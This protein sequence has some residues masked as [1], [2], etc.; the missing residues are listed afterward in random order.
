MKKDSQNFS[1]C[2]QIFG[3]GSQVFAQNST[4]INSKFFTTELSFLEKAHSKKAI[5]MKLIA[6]SNKQTEYGCN[7]NF[8]HLS[9]FEIEYVYFIIVNNNRYAGN[10]IV[11][12]FFF[13]NMHKNCG[14]K[15]VRGVVR[16][17]LGQ[18]YFERSRK[19]IPIEIY[20]IPCT[21]SKFSI[22]TGF[23]CN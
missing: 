21:L 15:S 5:K 19:N 12:N 20:F 23:L 17:N 8:L 13:M 9:S 3:T 4:F 2:A 10:I 1:F 6:T 18:V 11:Q 14:M 22:I 7:G 16:K